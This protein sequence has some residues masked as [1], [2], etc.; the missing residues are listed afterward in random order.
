MNM[1]SSLI[2]RCGVVV[3]ATSALFIQACGGGAPAPERSSKAEA[4]D[5]ELEIRTLSNRADLIS[6]GDAL[7]EVRVPND[8]PLQ[9]VALTLNGA[10]VGAAFV[11]D[12]HARTLRGVLRGLRVGE[13]HFVAAANG[14]GEDQPR[15]TLTITNHP[16]GGPVRL[17]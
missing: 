1:Y 6:N 10:N 2:L 11:S 16:P 3:L 15:A 13:H 14:R 7:V 17:R 5:N 9:N 4:P 12:Q 8:V